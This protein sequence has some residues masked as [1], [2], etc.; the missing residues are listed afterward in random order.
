V[1]PR[2]EDVRHEADTRK[3]RSAHNRRHVPNTGMVAMSQ[4]NSSAVKPP[5]RANVRKRILYQNGCPVEELIPEILGVKQRRTQSMPLVRGGMRSLRSS[6]FSNRPGCH[7][8]KYDDLAAS[9]QHTNV[10]CQLPCATNTDSRLGAANLQQ[11]NAIFYP[12]PFRSAISQPP[13]LPERVSCCL[14]IPSYSVLACMSHC[15][16]LKE[17]NDRSQLFFLSESRGEPD[18]RRDATSNEIPGSGQ[19][20]Y[21]DPERQ[22]RNTWI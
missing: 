11:T 18:G 5:I 22:G 13:R 21:P 12:F 6:V 16:W 4:L 20:C 8:S 19:N 9:V 17:C 15:R 10:N 7:P 2:F 1:T 14:R 3:Q